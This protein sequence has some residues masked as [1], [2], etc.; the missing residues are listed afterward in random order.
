MRCIFIPSI[1]GIT[2]TGCSCRQINYCTIRSIY[3]FNIVTA[4]NII[5]K[6]KFLACIVNAQYLIRIVSNQDILITSFIIS[7]WI[8]VDFRSY[9]RI[10]YTLFRFKVAY[11][12]IS[13]TCKILQVMSY[14]ILAIRLLKLIVFAKNIFPILQSKITLLYSNSWSAWIICRFIWYF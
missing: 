9:F 5:R 6:S 12:R 14:L 3:S 11:K 13:I 7:I 2:C 8:S 1:K 4:L 10:L